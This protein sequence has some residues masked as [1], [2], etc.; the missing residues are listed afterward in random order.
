MLAWNDYCGNPG[1]VDGVWVFDLESGEK[2][3]VAEECAL[4]GL[5]WSPDS[6]EIAYTVEYTTFSGLRPDPSTAGLY[7]VNL[8]SGQVRRI[9]NPGPGKASAYWGEAVDVGVEWLADGQGFRVSRDHYYNCSDC[10]GAP[11]LVL[12]SPD[13]SQETP[14]TEGQVEAAS[15]TSVAYTNDDGLVIAGPDG[16]D[17]KVLLRHDDDWRFSLAQF[18]PD[19]EWIAFTRV[20]CGDCKIP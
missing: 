2:R 7:V 15:E 9:T 19:A 6:S 5:V 12:V 13:G 10:G 8:A 18:S 4:I 17:G 14:I 16:G 20:Q 11:E 3:R 1:G